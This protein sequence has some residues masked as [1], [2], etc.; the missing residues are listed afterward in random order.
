MIEPYLNL[1]AV[2]GHLSFQISAVIAWSSRIW[3]QKLWL[4]LLSHLPSD[5]LQVRHVPVYNVY[6]NP[7]PRFRPRDALTR[8]WCLSE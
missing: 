4:L 8:A 1:S 5:S 6:A 7:K 3:Q 2:E